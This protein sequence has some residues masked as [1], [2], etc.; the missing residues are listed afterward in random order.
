MKYLLISIVLSFGCSGADG[1]VGSDSGTSDMSKTDMSTSDPKMGLDIPDCIR[2]GT[3][4]IAPSI[5]VGN[6][7]EKELS[8]TMALCQAESGVGE[9]WIYRIDYFSVTW[10]GEIYEIER[11]NLNYENSHHNW[12]DRLEARSD[13][14]E[15]DW[16]VEYKNE[17]APEFKHTLSGKI[18]TE[19]LEKTIMDVQCDNCGYFQFVLEE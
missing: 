5:L 1:K 12:F 4:K 19:V 9:S 3:D 11:A 15:F 17:V 6:N 14:A 2:E 8:F 7:T 16:A 18:G 10:K 13:M